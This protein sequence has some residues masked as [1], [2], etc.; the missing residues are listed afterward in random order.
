MGLL[1]N[2]TFLFRLKRFKFDIVLL[3]LVIVTKL[4]WQIFNLLN[5]GPIFIKI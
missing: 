1:K 3:L 2:E 4:F 5:S